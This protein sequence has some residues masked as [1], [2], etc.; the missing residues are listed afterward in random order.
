MGTSATADLCRLKRDLV[1]VKVIG[2]AFAEL[3]NELP[4][5]RLEISKEKIRG[6]CGASAAKAAGDSALHGAGATKHAPMI[7]EKRVFGCRV[8]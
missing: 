5:L 2:S 8:L 6:C 1:S 3:V 7:K 4:N